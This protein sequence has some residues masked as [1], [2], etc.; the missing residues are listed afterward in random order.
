[1]RSVSSTLGAEKSLVCSIAAGVGRKLVPHFRM[2]ADNDIVHH[3][4]VAHNAIASQRTNRKIG[5][6]WF[7]F[8]WCFGSVHHHPI[9][10]TFVDKHG[11]LRYLRRRGA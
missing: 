11:R 3:T 5:W 10:L 6:L 2:K 7:C 9:L 8:G 4:K 1:M